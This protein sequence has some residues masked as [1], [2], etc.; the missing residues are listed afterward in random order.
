MDIFLVVGWMVAPK[1]MAA[2]AQRLIE[3]TCKKQGVKK[4]DIILQ[5]DRGS[6]M[7]AKT[8]AQLCETLGISKS[9]SGPH[10]SND[11]PYWDG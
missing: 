8:T 6:P 5:A 7:I 10:V 1:E 9:H 3:A 11:N 4:G 2:L